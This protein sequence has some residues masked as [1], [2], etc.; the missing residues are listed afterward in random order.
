MN[1]AKLRSLLCQA[2]VI[3][4]NEIKTDLHIALPGYVTYMNSTD[5]H[6]GGVAV[7]VRKNLNRF[8]VHMDYS[9]K[10]Q[11]RFRF[12]FCPKIL[13]IACYVPPSDS[14]FFSLEAIAGLDA[15][16]QNNRNDLVVILGDLNCRY[17]KLQNRFLSCVPPSWM[18]HNDT[19][20]QPNQNARRLVNTLQHLVMLNGLS[21]GPEPAGTSFSSAPT[22]R[23]GNEWIST[24]DHVY[25]SPELVDYVRSFEIRNETWIPSDHAP[26]FCAIAT[27][28]PVGIDIA[29]LT[30]RS[31]QLGSHDFPEKKLCQRQ[32]RWSDLDKPVVK[33]LLESSPPPPMNPSDIEGMTSE[34]ENT[35]RDYCQKGRRTQP[36]PSPC[37]DWQELL[38]SGD[39]KSVWY[40][41]DWSGRVHGNKDRPDSD[42]ARPNDD[43]FKDHFERLLN[44]PDQPPP[45]R[46]DTGSLYIPLTD[47]PITPLEVD[48]AIR[49]IK[50]NKSGGPSGI[51]PGILHLLPM[52]WILFLA[53]LFTAI[54]YSASIPLSWC[55]SRLIVLF[56]KGSTSDCNNYR[57]ISVMETFAK[58]YDLILC[59]RLELWRK[60]YREQAG[61]QKGRGCTEHILSLR[62]LFDYALSKKTK[63]FVLFVD[64]SKAYDRVPRQALVSTLVSLGCGAAMT[65]AIATLYGD[66]RMILGSAVVTT[67][68]GLRQGSPTSCWLFTAYIDK[69]VRLVREK[70][71]NDGFLGWLHCLLL[72]DDTV[73][74]ATSWER[75]KKKT[76][77]LIEFCNDSGMVI[78]ESKTKHMVIN[79][80]NE[81]RAPLQ[82]DDLTVA[83]CESYT[84]LGA[85]FTQ[86]GK[87]RSSLEQHLNAKKG[88]VLKFVSFLEKNKD[89][90]FW[91]KRKVMESA[92]LSAILYGCEAWINGSASMVEVTYRSLIKSLL[93]V[94]ISTPND[95]C[96]VELDCPSAEAM[97][98][99]IQRKFLSRILKE[100][101]RMTDDPFMHVWSICSLANTK[102]IKYYK[103]ILDINGSH[104]TA[105]CQSRLT[106]MLNSEK[107][108]L[109]EYRELN[110]SLSQ[111]PIYTDPIVREY[112]RVVATRLRLGSHDLMVERGRWSRLPRENCL[113]ECG[114]I[115][116]VEHI[117]CYCPLT[118]EVREKYPD[119][120][121]AS[122][123][124]FWEN[125]DPKTICEI[126][127]KCYAIL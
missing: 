29:Q 61:A 108:K 5:G 105:D 65:L 4:L 2:N 70:C 91:V 51:S 1:N 42:L 68:I 54:F 76:E 36:E 21:T 93:G 39:S 88:N 109:S 28:R 87:P 15:T 27:D 40:A 120:N 11:I 97:V 13:F 17:A 75:L 37:N 86:D 64:F 26:I 60:P 22:Y 33:S 59:R 83:N 24:L 114:K 25:M 82:F 47:D 10:D 107:T 44:P 20:K 84:Y 62:L 103:G 7:F 96:H 95:I 72:M 18:Y 102:A 125:P 38:K 79:G 23:Q 124:L 115:Q 100:R 112:E 90:P 80:S 66:A 69:F 89:F 46:A 34:L 35:I 98:M 57:G 121:F 122:I 53:H 123:R 19:Q 9:V 71:P 16:L 78:N 48:D 41:I 106:R 45:Q 85:I 127:A 94:R 116:T 101:A 63:L 30:Q 117:I 49:T 74:V 119:T 6:R 50:P 14:P 58:V 81:D 31:T 12:K 73:I 67:S 8:V 56:K 104:S 113:C 32:V 92:L 110:P 43:T 126:S 77:V 3:C 118:Q 111:P 52:T 55:F 99:D